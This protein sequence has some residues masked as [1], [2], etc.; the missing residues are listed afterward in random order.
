MSAQRFVLSAALALALSLS[1][2]TATSPSITNSPSED[3]NAAIAVYKRVVLNFSN[4]SS[5]PL[6]VKLGWAYNQQDQPIAEEWQTMQPGSQQLLISKQTYIGDNALYVHIRKPGGQKGIFWVVN[7]SD[8]TANWAVL[9]DASNEASGF[10]YS[11]AVLT[12][13]VA[14]IKNPIGDKSLVVAV[15]TTGEVTNFGDQS[16]Y[17]FDAFVT[18]A[19]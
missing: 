7:G 11:K 14:S 12:P 13:N 8:F 10:F 6:D 4:L 19:N 16:G 9:K 15:R 5:K 1:G 2:C 17:F 18:D 3:R